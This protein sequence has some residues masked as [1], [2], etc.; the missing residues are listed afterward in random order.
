MHDL[1]VI[2][3]GPYG[4]AVA[5]QAKHCGLDFII[6]GEPM[7]FWHEHMP[8]D[9]LLRSPWPE[10][11]LAD[12]LGRFRLDDYVR[13]QG[14]GRATQD[15]IPL[16]LFLQYAA[17][18]RR[19]EGLAPWQCMVAGVE[20]HNGTFTVTL[21][22]GESLRAR[23]VVVATGLAYFSNVPPVFQTLPGHLWAHSSQLTSFEHFA[24]QRVL[25][26]GAGQS[27]LESAALLAESGAAV[28]L[29]CR[30]QRV[31]Y[32]NITLGVSSPRIVK[33]AARAIQTTF[34]TLPL[35]LRQRIMA[36]LESGSGAPWVRD[37][38]AG[39]VLIRASTLVERLREG[40]DG[41]EVTFS[42]ETR[43]Q[44]HFI[45]VCTGYK[46][47]LSRLSFLSS[48]TVWPQL[49]LSNGYPRLDRQYQSTVRGMYFVGH[50]STQ[51]FG[52]LGRT[53][54]GS[55]WQARSIIS[56]IRH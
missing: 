21:D 25:V 47:N 12:P 52:P 45:V 54:V 23:N 1:I 2:G 43:T 28:E 30:G 39:R 29:A 53:A 22:D 19:Q 38:I 55:A 35:S 50:M 9:M 42:G 44:V 56:H 5:A 7:S 3:A 40:G 27:A 14:L 6:L 49:E 41:I 24:N 15:P 46:V 8:K 34:R 37:R 48:G 11:S 18:F 20:W 33:W 4:F 32:R 36:K 51:D 17:W 31:Y 13:L 10:S 16:K 26:I